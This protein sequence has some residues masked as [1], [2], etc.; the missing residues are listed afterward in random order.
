M[1]QIALHETIKRP[2]ELHAVEAR[3]QQLLTLVG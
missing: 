2:E 1:E 3:Q